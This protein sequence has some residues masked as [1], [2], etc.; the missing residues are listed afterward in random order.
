MTPG[1]SGR[2][3]LIPILMNVMELFF[4]P[5]DAVVI[6]NRKTKLLQKILDID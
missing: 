2:M 6:I 3:L 4:P 1:M 5:D